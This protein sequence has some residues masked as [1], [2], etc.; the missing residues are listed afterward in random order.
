MIAIEGP[1]LDSHDFEVLEIF[2]ETS[3]RIVKLQ[4]FYTFFSIKKFC[5]GKKF[6]GGGGK[7]TVGEGEGGKEFQGSLVYINPT[8]S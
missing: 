8:H 6:R 1:E 3:S 7:L 2:K 4:I 5:Q